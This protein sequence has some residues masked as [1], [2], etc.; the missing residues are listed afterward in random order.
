MAIFELLLTKLLIVMKIEFQKLKEVK[1]LITKYSELDAAAVDLLTFKELEIAYAYA[2]L[3]AN[4]AI[5]KEYVE[6]CI[7]NPEQQITSTELEE[8]KPILDTLD[9]EVLYIPLHVTNTGSSGYLA[10]SE[11]AEDLCYESFVKSTR[12]NELAE[13]YDVFS[14]WFFQ[15]T[16][17]NLVFGGRTRNQ[18]LQDIVAK[19]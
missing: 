6:H 4:R 3:K 11:G 13:P 8:M 5:T 1:E 14:E 12:Q 18:K 9:Y 17:R 2:Y 10:T 7:N 19:F 16:S 15:H